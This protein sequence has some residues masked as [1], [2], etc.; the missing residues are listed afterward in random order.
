MDVTIL[1]A[2]PEH[3]RPAAAALYWQ[4]FGGKLGRVLGP[5]DRGRAFVARALRT[6]HAL[7]AV[8]GDRLIGI[9]GIKTVRGAFVAGGADTM[10][11][12]YGRFGAAWRRSALGLLVQDTDNARFL[13][14]G[15][16]VA[17][18]ER[19]RGVGT[20][21]LGAVAVRA[22]AAGYAELRLD[23]VEHNTAA[24]RLYERC[25]F[26]IVGRQPARA[27]ALFGFSATLTM[28]RAV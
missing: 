13:I 11:P 3:H 8:R 7:A 19:G 20:A 1:D 18:G 5:D 25:G 23:V 27:A 9:C 2:L 24:R 15:L 17:E 26:V 28:V 4:A 14:D 10:R 16:C 21:L 6:D 22:R 12:V